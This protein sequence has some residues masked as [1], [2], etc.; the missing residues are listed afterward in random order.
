MDGSGPAAA[1]DAPATPVGSTTD[2]GDPLVLLLGVLGL[3]AALVVA[4][5]VCCGSKYS[6]IEAK[7]AI[8]G[9]VTAV[10]PKACKLKTKPGK[11]SPSP[12]EC[13]EPLVAGTE[14]IINDLTPAFKAKDKTEE[15]W[16]S[17][18]VSIL[19]GRGT[20][21]GF[22]PEASVE[23]L[24]AEPE[25]KSCC[26]RCGGGGGGG[27]KPQKARASDEEAPE[28]EPMGLGSSPVSEP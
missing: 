1:D 12:K 7:A 20:V 25:A 16:L 28:M 23:Q 17:V 27:G 6:K 3:L 24:E 18:S 10:D 4:K 21:T 19:G 14:I 8:R 13:K 2:G 11:F 22:L 9:R 15:P 5:R 26:W